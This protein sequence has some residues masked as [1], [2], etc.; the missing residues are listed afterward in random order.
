MWSDF[1]PVR[2]LLMVFV[3]RLHAPSLVVHN[4]PSYSKAAK[5]VTPHTA[6]I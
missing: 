6:R 3:P 1:R 5:G 2:Y 4:E